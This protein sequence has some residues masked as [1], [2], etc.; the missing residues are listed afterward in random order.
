MK[1]KFCGCTEQAACSIAVREADDGSAYVETGVIEQL[2]V[3]IN[4]VPCSWLLPNVCSAPVC[5]EKAYAE[6]AL[7]ASQLQFWIEREDAA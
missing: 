5:V 6:A 3:D 7:L 1:C 2:S 4:Y